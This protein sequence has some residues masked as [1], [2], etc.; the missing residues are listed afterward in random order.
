MHVCTHECTQKYTIFPC[1]KLYC[2]SFQE[3]SEIFYKFDEEPNNFPIAVD[4]VKCQGSE[5][6]LK[7]CV[8]FSHSYSECGH[9]DDVG[10]RCQ[11]GLCHT[12]RK[13]QFPVILLFWAIICSY[14]SCT[15]L[16]S[17]F[18]A[19]CEDGEVR[20]LDKGEMEGFV[21]VCFNKRWSTLCKSQNDANLYAICTQMGYRDGEL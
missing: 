7:D 3:A 13:G 14:Y 18:I 15:E 8:H 5:N 12:L 9:S 10:V 21:L 11:P 2:F 20:F 17:S 6:S 16:F 19:N 4:Y 1:C